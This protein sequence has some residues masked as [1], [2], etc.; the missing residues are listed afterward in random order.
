VAGIYFIQVA[1]LRGAPA[2]WQLAASLP[3]PVFLVGL[4]AGAIVTAVMLV[5]DLRDRE[6]DAAKGWRTG[7]VRFGPA[8]S[9][10]EIAFLLAFAWLAP[11]AFWGALG[12]GPWVLLPVVAAPLAYRM[13]RAVRTARE[14]TELIPLTPAMARLAVIHSILLALGLALSR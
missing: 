3:L 14:R 12:F 1:A 2:P 5:D 7:A 13:L 9:R 8:F 4:P 11:F 6:F 10:A